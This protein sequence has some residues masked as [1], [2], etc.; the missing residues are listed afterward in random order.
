M[1][2]VLDHSA[3]A[4]VFDP[5]G[6]IRLYVKDDATIDAIAGDVRELLAGK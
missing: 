5:A 4:Y 6:R 3:G 1:A 2:Y